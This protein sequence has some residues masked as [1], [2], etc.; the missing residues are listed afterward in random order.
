M[1]QRR[2]CLVVREPTDHEFHASSFRGQRRFTRARAIIPE[3]GRCRAGVG[4]PG[5]GTQEDSG[6]VVHV[7]QQ[8]LQR[9]GE[10][11]DGQC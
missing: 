11:G 10:G 8:A 2:S 7:L 6:R 4:R 1:M 9:Q 5:A 3:E